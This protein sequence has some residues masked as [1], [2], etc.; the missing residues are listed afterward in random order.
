[1][2]ALPPIT[3]YPQGLLW[4]D[5]EAAPAPGDMLRSATVSQADWKSWTT[6]E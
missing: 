6:L 5:H 2:T 3:T 1:M 4:L